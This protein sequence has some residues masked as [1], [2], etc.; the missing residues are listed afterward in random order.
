MLKLLTVKE[1]ESI[2][3]NE[4]NQY[5]IENIGNKVYKIP[6]LGYTGPKGV[7]MYVNELRNK[8]NTFNYEDFV[9]TLNNHK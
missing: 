5:G 7:T 4:N 2:L 9:D 8:I 3:S 6:G 1:V